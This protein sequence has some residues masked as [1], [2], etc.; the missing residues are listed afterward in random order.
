M[1]LK[2]LA[3]RF[4]LVQSLPYYYLPFFAP[5]SILKTC[6]FYFSELGPDQ[7][8]RCVS[9]FGTLSALSFASIFGIL[10]LENLRKIFAFRWVL[11]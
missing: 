1:N 9:I 8:A 5:T 3:F 6:D 11:G 2:I 7:F 4:N 10:G